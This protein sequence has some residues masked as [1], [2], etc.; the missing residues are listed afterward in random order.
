MTFHQVIFY[1]VIPS[2]KRSEDSLYS[3]LEISSW[4]RCLKSVR[5]TTLITQGASKA[6]WYPTPQNLSILA[7]GRCQECCRDRMGSFQGTGNKATSPK[8]SNL[9]STYPSS[10]PFMSEQSALTYKLYSDI[11]PLLPCF[12]A[13]HYHPTFIHS[14]TFRRRKRYLKKKKY[15]KTPVGWRE[16]AKY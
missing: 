6:G 7:P 11:T 15:W 12:M 8:I 4:H 13:A 14:Q 1:Y 9:S 3:H 10:P 16:N 5:E 2:F